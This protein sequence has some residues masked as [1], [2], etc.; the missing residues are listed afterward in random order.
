MPRYNDPSRTQ[1]ENPI[2]LRTTFVGPRRNFGGGGPMPVNP[3]RP[4]NSGSTMKTVTSTREDP[5]YVD[6]DSTTT[7]S[8]SYTKPLPDTPDARTFVTPEYDE[9]EVAKQTQM[10]AGSGIRGL[11]STLQQAIGT[12]PSSSNPNVRRMTLRDALA[13]YGQ[14]LESVMGGAQSRAANIYGQK[15]AAETAAGKINFNAQVR[16]DEMDFEK[17]MTEWEGSKVTT[18]ER[19][20]PSSDDAAVIPPQQPTFS[21][22]FRSY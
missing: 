18:T 19:G 3:S 6:P 8:T 20:V 16:R 12:T 5:G 14:G 2:D 15:F 10:Q 22:S 9:R 17:L 7:R 4:A 13:G 1:A 21:R 11:R